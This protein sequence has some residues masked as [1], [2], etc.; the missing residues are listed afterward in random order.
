MLHRLV[1]RL[2]HPAVD[3]YLHVDRRVDPTPFRTSHI[4][5]VERR[6]PVVWN[7]FGL[8]Q[9]SLTWLRQVRTT[10]YR[11]L[12]FL[13]GQ[14]YPARRIE[15]FL[16]YLEGGSGILLDMQW[17]DVFERAP[18]WG[19]FHVT[20]PNPL[21]QLGDKI[22]RRMPWNRGFRLLPSG[23]RFGCGSALWT[24]SGRSVDWMLDFLDER[25]D[26]ERFFRNTLHSDEMFYQTVLNSSPFASELGDHRHYINWSAKCSHPKLL[27]MED[28]VAIRESGMH[29]IRKVD[30]DQSRDLMDALD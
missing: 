25:P 12:S 4:Q 5:E 27:D 10:G 17:S 15:D 24:L 18:R 19:R 1:E 2:R 30:F 16:E 3:I 29:F 22:R 21:R 14:D 13:S 26:V 28:L 20:D 23:L 6:Y 9:A 11:T 8:V 7:G